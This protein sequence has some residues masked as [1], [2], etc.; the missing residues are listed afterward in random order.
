MPEEFRLGGGNERALRVLLSLKTTKTYEDWVV[1]NQIGWFYR[2][3]EGIL[4]KLPEERFIFS[5]QIVF[6][7]NLTNSV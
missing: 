1:F 5:P 6:Y 2:T 7:Q 4:K 3:R